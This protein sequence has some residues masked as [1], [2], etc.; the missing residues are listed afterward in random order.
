MENKIFNNE[1]EVHS[2]AIRAIYYNTKFGEDLHFIDNP[3]LDYNI[4]YNILTHTENDRDHIMILNLDIVEP[5]D[6]KDKNEFHIVVEGHFEVSKDIENELIDNS[7]QFRSLGILLT[8]L[9]TTIFN[10]TSM[11]SSGGFNLPLINVEELHKNYFK[12]EKTQ[13][14]KRKKN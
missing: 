13:K 6:D 2:L 10:I 7:I 4:E 14:K 1:I 5:S 11:T 9:R 12:K 3:D 8:F